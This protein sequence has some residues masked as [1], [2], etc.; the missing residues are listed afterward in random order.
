MADAKHIIAAA[1]APSAPM[2]T[3]VD[4]R[5][6]PLPGVKAVLFDVYGTLFVSG[7]GDIGVAAKTRSEKAFLEAFAAT[8]GHPVQ[9][10][11]EI[12]AVALLEREIKAAHA[13]LRAEGVDYPEIDIRRMWQAVLDTLAGLGLAAAGTTPEQAAELGLRYELSVNPVWPMPGAAEVI[14]NLRGRGLALGIV[15]NAQC[16]TRLL[17]PALL[18]ADPA[19]LGFDQDL[20]VW[21]YEHGHGKPSDKLYRVA[22]E[23]LA[24]RGVAPGEILFVGNDML[25]D[26]TPPARRGWRTALFA[27]DARSLRLREGDRRCRGIRP[28]AV[29]TALDQLPPLLPAGC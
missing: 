4:P 10:P 13:K 16:Y 26:I 22:E 12:S 8:F 11:A 1:S 25:N 7:S 28:D 24:T 14:R 29:L 3:G 27:G 18:A 23:V 19:E 5:L 2:P 6:P 17:F 21:S 15:S 9:L 20:C